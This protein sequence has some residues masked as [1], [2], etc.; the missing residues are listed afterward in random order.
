MSHDLRHFMNADGAECRTLDGRLHC[1]DGPA[2]ICQDGTKEWWLY[3]QLHR[4]DGPAVIFPDGEEVEYWQ[5]SL[6]HREDGPAIE[7]NDIKVWY[8]EGNRHRLDGPAVIKPDG[9]VG[10]WVRGIHVTSMKHFR[11]LTG[12]SDEELSL[13][14]L[15]YGGI[16]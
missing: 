14:A 13:L 12:I 8:I 5:N 2:R 16:K 7:R 3:G 1:E 11:E 6:L 10:W 4:E 9:S 15:K